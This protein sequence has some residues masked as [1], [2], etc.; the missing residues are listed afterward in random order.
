MV[1]DFELPT[2]T[3]VA[4]MNLAQLRDTHQELVVMITKQLADILFCIEK[5][6][7]GQI[8]SDNH[9]E[10]AY[11]EVYVKANDL[12]T[13]FYIALEVSHHAYLESHRILAQ[14]EKDKI[15]NG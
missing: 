15:N 2:P 12:L 6:F 1:S 5:L 9:V 3:K 10:I 7:A 14:I 4:T 11:H 13:V 8:T